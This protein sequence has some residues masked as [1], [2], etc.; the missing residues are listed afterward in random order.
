M[1]R[2]PRALIS[3]LAVV[4]FA[5]CNSESMPVARIVPTAH[6]WTARQAR[7]QDLLYIT[8]DHTQVYVF[9]YPGTYSIGI[10]TPDSPGSECADS[11]GH[12]F[13][14]GKGGEYPTYT[15]VV[16]EY[17]HGGS[18]PL[19]TL[20]DAASNPYG[21]SIDPT[22]GNLAVTDNCPGSG[23][24]Q[25]R[26]D[27]AI[28]LHAKGQPKRYVDSAIASYYYCSYDGSGDLFLDG[29]DSDGAFRFAELP[30]GA[31]KFTNISLEVKIEKPG[32]VEWDGQYVA[33]G[34]Q[35][36]KIYRIDGSGG[37]VEGTISLSGPQKLGSLEI[38]QFW[39]QGSILIGPGR[40]S[41]TSGYGG[42]GFVGFWHYPGGGSPVGNLG[43]IGGS[44]A[45]VSL[46]K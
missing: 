10:L 46:A 8:D 14:T 20:N 43:A 15:G 17:A 42:G 33:V 41:S 45:A 23:T 24:T 16:F 3:C 5:S 22:S 19:A 39:I 38:Q 30:K 21:C 37:K 40:G 2:I 11:S 28:Y 36:N 32:G 31:T 1:T 6:V 9:T 13:I 7:A 25:C 44:G 18:K 34:N 4:A 26:G 35:G 29:T 12:V 27:V